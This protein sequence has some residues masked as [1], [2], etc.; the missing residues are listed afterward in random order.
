MNGKLAKM[1][2]IGTS[3][4]WSVLGVFSIFPAIFSV[5]MF[6]AP[7]SG[8]NPATLALAFS[9]LT[10]PVI[11]LFSV[12]ISWVL[13]SKAAYSKSCIWALLPL[14]N[15]VVGGAGFAWI[16]LMQDGKFAL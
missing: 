6:D 5:M 15:L 11:C 13:Y 7:G 8:K 3:I 2:V 16:S 4:A 14:V 9:L 12:T 1:C 10:L